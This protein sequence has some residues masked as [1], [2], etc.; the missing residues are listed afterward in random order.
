MIPVFL[1]WNVPMK[2]KTK[3]QLNC[4]FGAGLLTAGLSIGR[5]AASND[6]VWETDNTC[7]FSYSCFLSLA[8]ATLQCMS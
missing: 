1:L 6:G 3:I 5:V 4:I 7:E 8:A 2:R